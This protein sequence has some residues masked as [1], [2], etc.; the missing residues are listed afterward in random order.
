[1]STIPTAIVNTMLA[2]TQRGRYCSGPVRTS[3]TNSTTPAKTS[4]ATWLRAPALRGRLHTEHVAEHRDA[5][6]KPNAGEKSNQHLARK[7]I[8]EEAQLEDPGQ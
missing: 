8:G 2:S 5:D 6:L 3:S 7:E 1:M 4:C